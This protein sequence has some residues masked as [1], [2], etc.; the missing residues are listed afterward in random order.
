MPRRNRVDPNGQLVADPAR[1]SLFGNRG[2][3]HDASGEIRRF[4]RGERWI[5][6]R[7]QF[8][9]RHRELLQPNQYTELFFY[10]E[11]TALAAGHRPCAECMRERFNEFRSAWGDGSCARAPE[12]DRVLHSARIDAG[13]EKVVF[14]RSVD[15][16]PSGVLVAGERGPELLFEGEL[17]AWTPGGYGEPRAAGSGR[18]RVLTPR[19]TVEAIARGF[20]P[21]PGVSVN[22]NSIERE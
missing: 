19:P 3:L 11:P 5:Y 14:E 15:E 21:Q 4:H 12:I 22:G 20:C 13:G 9:G 17:R 6:C 10:D 2:C 18:T 16:L 8:K 1:G 7:L